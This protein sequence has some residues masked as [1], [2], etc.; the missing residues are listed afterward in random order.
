MYRWLTAISIVFVL[1]GVVR[2][3]PPSLRLDTDTAAL[4]AELEAFVPELMNKGHVPGLQLALI[5]DGK[6]I[7]HK[8]FGV[9]DV[10]GGDPVTDETI[11]EA[12][13]LTKPLFA[14]AVMMLIEEGVLDL[15]TPLITHFSDDEIE[16]F[17]GHPLDEPEFHREWAE[18]ITARQVLSHSAGM[19]HGEGG[20][21]YPLFF[22]PGTQYK[23]SAAGYA[24]LALAVEKLK[25]KRLDAII[26]NYVLDPLEM[27][28][29]SMVW[30]DAYDNTMAHGHDILG[31]S[32]AFRKYQ[33]PHAAASLYTTATDYAR[34]VC[35]VLNGEGIKSETLKEML[36]PQIDVDE[37]RGLTWSLGF[38]LQEDGNGP[39][40]W[41]WGDYGIFR[42]YIIA[43]PKQE[44]GVV[45]LTNSFYGL[46]ICQDLV[47][48]SIGGQ[49]VG[50]AFLEYPR[51]DSPLNDFVWAVQAQGAGVVESR[52]PDLM[53]EYPDVFTE[54]LLGWVASKFNEAGKYDEGIA[55]LE[56]SV[57]QH[58]QS[59]QAYMDLARAY[60]QKGES[61]PARG[62][63][64]KVR[65]L[66]ENDEEFDM[67]SLEWA[68]VYLQALEAPADLSR[69]HLSKLA[70]DYETRHFEVRDDGLY[71]FREGTA[72]Q[73]FRRLTAVSEDT[74]VVEGLIYF[75]LQFEFDDG[76]H[77]IKVVGLYEWGNTDQ[78]IR[79]R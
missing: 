34:F 20:D 72:T 6:V 33:E 14:Y 76:G 62:Y 45:Y 56:V 38:G 1:A 43:Y 32:Q 4:T 78:S 41:Q 11:F 65:E 51:Y 36:T 48:A 29:S 63:Y 2:A 59:P 68:L 60:L 3:T 53:S 7:W 35:A 79:D 21:V 26:K 39:A 46:G 13:S 54:R 44:I 10:E 8:G 28:R 74:F 71:Y 42:N 17:L 73:E 70:G 23:Y 75:R 37:E 58:P 22:E 24:Y 25:G 15:D 12:A 5:R 30:R 55:M 27:E 69:D 64:D 49:A 9:T 19:P 40:F 77:P 66:A 67:S 31:I 18:V 61:A 47:S 57:E 52:L 16:G 50:V